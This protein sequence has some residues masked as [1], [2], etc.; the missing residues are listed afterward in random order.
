MRMNPIDFGC[1]KSKVKVTMDIFR[2]K[3]STR[4]RLNRCVLLGH[5]SH[6]ERLNPIGCGGQRSKI[7]VT[8]E[9][10]GNKLIITI[11]T[12]PLCISSSNFSEMLTIANPINFGDHS[13]KV[14]VTIVIIDKCGVCGDATL[15]VVIFIMT[16]VGNGRK[17]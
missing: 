17:K 4:K 8:M 2:K 1:Q 13:S 5:V 6:S 10:Y 12:K 9:I 3:L 7:R 15:C 14:K 16:T 11:E